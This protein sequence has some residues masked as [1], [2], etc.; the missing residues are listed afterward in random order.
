MDH[1]DGLVLAERLF[2]GAEAGFGGKLFKVDFGLA[3]LREEEARDVLHE[4]DV[5]DLAVEVLAV[6]H[7]AGGLDAGEGILALALGLLQDLAEATLNRESHEELG[8]VVADERRTREGLRL[9]GVERRNHVLGE[10]VLKSGPGGDLLYGL[11]ESPFLRHGGV[12]V[13][14][15]QCHKQVGGRVDREITA[16]AEGVFL[17]LHGGDVTELDRAH[18]PAG[19]DDPRIFDLLVF[20]EI[21]EDLLQHDAHFLG[22]ARGISGQLAV[23]RGHETPVEAVVDQDDAVSGIVE[24]FGG[25]KCG[26]AVVDA[27]DAGDDDGEF[28]GRDFVFVLRLRG[29]EETVFEAGAFGVDADLDLP[30]VDLVLEIGVEDGEARIPPVVVL[31]RH[32]VDCAERIGHGS[33]RMIAFQNLAAAVKGPG[34]R[35]PLVGR[36][37]G[38]AFVVDVLRVVIVP[39]VELELAVQELHH[40]IGAVWVGGPLDHVHELR[41]QRHDVVDVRPAGVGQ[42]GADV[43]QIVEDAADVVANVDVLAAGDDET[44]ARADAPGGEHAPEVGI[45]L[46]EVEPVFG[47]VEEPGD[48]NGGVQQ[49]TPRLDTRAFPFRAAERGDR[50]A[51]ERE[52]VAGVFDALDHGTRQDAGP[53]PSQR[54]RDVVH[55]HAVDLEHAPV[56]AFDRVVAGK[57]ADQARGRPRSGSV[58]FRDGSLLSGSFLLW[59]GASACA[60]KQRGNDH[61]CGQKTV[62]EFRFHSGAPFLDSGRIYT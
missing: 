46:V 55:D 59:L 51:R 38:Q 19:E 10:D 31:L 3:V 18:G 20:A 9:L 50:A 35:G 56:E 16:D 49:E 6:E 32:I 26:L 2:D 21:G 47:W 17:F 58:G 34:H 52:V 23:G 12:I 41:M 42:I 61:E 15:L 1:A 33:E 53:D 60:Q 37:F 43:Q 29:L 22:V 5:A 28:F 44:A 40:H 57:L 11:V 62:P 27:A 24:L 48:A 54:T 45:G 13:A 4:P 14:G 25:G 36:E 8:D 7:G 39:F 30:R